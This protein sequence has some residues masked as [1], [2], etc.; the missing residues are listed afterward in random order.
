MPIMHLYS[1]HNTTAV[2]L[3]SR[4]VAAGVLPCQQ[5]HTY[6][7]SADRMLVPMTSG[8]FSHFAQNCIVYGNKQPLYKEWDESPVVDQRSCPKDRLW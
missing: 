7:A 2:Q 6:L 1:Q 8:Q 3:A 4:M 5:Y